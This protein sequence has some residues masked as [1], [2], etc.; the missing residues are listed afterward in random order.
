MSNITTNRLTI[1]G[2]K[3]DLDLFAATMQRPGFDEDRKPG[4]FCFH[5][6]VP[7][8]A[9][10]F[11]GT[12]GKEESEKYPN[13]LNWLGWSIANWGTKWP[14][15][16]TDPAVICNESIF[17]KFD[18]A[19]S[20]PDIWMCTASIQFPTLRFKNIWEIECVGSGYSVFRNG[21]RVRNIAF[22]VK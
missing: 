12:L 21:N 9:T 19:N 4:E 1:T 18:T 15:Y 6:T 16:H 7:M 8:P 22:S 2:P 14:N 17:I 3:K 11:R 10:V 5:Q 13:E 20:P